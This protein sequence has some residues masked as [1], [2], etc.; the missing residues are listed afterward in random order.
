MVQTTQETLLQETTTTPALATLPEVK[1]MLRIVGWIG[2][3]NLL[4]GIPSVMLVLS[5]RSLPLV[6][7]GLLS[8]LTFWLLRMAAAGRNSVSLPCAGSIF[9]ALSCGYRPAT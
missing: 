4:L 5:F 3:A 7:S 6:F 9:Q 1:T 2:W 8:I